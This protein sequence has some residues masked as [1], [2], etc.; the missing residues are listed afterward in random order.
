MIETT[1]TKIG[2]RDVISLLKSSTDSS[3]Q[4]AMIDRPKISP[5]TNAT[6]NVTHITAIVLNNRNM[7]NLPLSEVDTHCPSDIVH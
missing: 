7:Y 6:A 5:Y 4:A 2:S 3:R 1:V